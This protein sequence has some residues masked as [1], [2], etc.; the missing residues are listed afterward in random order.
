VSPCE[1]QFQGKNKK[2]GKN[3]LQSCKCSAVQ[4]NPFVLWAPPSCPSQ[5]PKSEQPTM[6]SFRSTFGQN[7]AQSCVLAP[8]CPLNPC[9]L[10][11]A[12][13][14]KNTQHTRATHLVRVLGPGSSLFHWVRTAR[15]GRFFNS[16]LMMF[17]PISEF[18]IGNF[19]IFPFFCVKWSEIKFS[20][21]NANGLGI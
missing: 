8:V 15:K 3:R 4:C 19:L 13:H 9:P 16:L 14:R 2:K 20:D 7:N 11:A 17:W 6:P 18:F 12:R 10:G 21:L 1:L 5:A